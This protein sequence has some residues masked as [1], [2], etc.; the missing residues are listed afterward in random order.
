LK[1]V[2]TSDNASLQNCENHAM[3]SECSVLRAERNFVAD[4]FN[5]Y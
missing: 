5:W 4:S 3:C 2:H 1:K